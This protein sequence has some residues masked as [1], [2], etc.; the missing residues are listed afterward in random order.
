MQIDGKRFSLVKR[1][2][3]KREP[4]TDFEV[5]DRI[6]MNA[7]A[8]EIGIYSRTRVGS[9]GKIEGTRE[10]GRYSVRFTKITGNYPDDVPVIYRVHRGH[11]ENLEEVV[12]GNR[13]ATA[14]DLEDR[15]LAELGKKV[16]VDAL[17]ERLSRDRII[18]L[19]RTQDVE[20]LAMAGREEYKGDGFGFVKHNGSYYAYIDVP[21]FAI[22]SQ[23]DGNYY[24]FDKSRVG[25]KI[26]RDGR[27]LSYGGNLVAI[28]NNNHPF[29]HNNKGRFAEF[30]T[31]KVDF[32]TSGNHKGEVIAKRL[33][34][35]REMVMFG[36]TGYSYKYSYQLTD[37]GFFDENRTSLAT[38]KK[39]GVPI[40]QGGSRK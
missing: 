3:E 11:M 23:F 18:D 14:S 12:V 22:K 29:L 37:N 40:I 2:E 1:K 24:L 26:G 32:P 33:R 36:Y 19:L 16:R 4:K 13:G 17:R 35:C 34:R 5:G 25:I 7:R 10:D 27:D 20:F 30:C 21:S 28:D 8:N 39:R 38:L 9:E 15:F 31:Y 6:R